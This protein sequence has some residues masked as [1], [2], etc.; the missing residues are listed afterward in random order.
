LQF[1]D[2]G[3]LTFSNFHF[4][5]R[6]FGFYF[7][8]QRQSPMPPQ[9]RRPREPPSDWHILH[10]LPFCPPTER[11]LPEPL[12]SQV[13]RPGFQHLDEPV[14]GLNFVGESRRDVMQRNVQSVR[15]FL[16]PRTSRSDYLTRIEF[17]AFSESSVQAMI[18]P[19][20]VE[21]HCSGCFSRCI[22]LESVIFE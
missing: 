3:H 18:I 5:F 4:G 9:L 17:Q 1:S 11:T 21:I 13:L 19:R 10:G 22:S 6:F 15:G 20:N 16:V 8:F 7:E 14:S 12:V 2:C